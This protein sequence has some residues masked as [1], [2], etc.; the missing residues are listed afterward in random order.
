[1]RTTWTEKEWAINIIKVEGRCSG[2]Q[3]LLKKPTGAC[4]Y[5]TF[6]SSKFGCNNPRLNY[7][8]A[9]T[10]FIDH[11]GKEELVEELL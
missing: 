4:G 7:E 5:C 3:S 11:Y 8:H 10:W 1:M 2:K 9:I 6:A